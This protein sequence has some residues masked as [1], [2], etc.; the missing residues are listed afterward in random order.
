MRTVRTLRGSGTADPPT[1]FSLFSSPPFQD[2]ERHDSQRPEDWRNAPAKALSSPVHLTSH[3][4]GQAGRLDGALQRRDPEDSLLGQTTP[5]SPVELDCQ[6]FS[7]I[8]VTHWLCGLRQVT[9][10]L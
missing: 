8:S 5:L 3:P 7:P 6:A 9:S 10:F 4:E 1:V 2:W